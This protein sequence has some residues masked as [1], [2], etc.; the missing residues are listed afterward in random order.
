MKNFVLSL[1]AIVLLTACSSESEQPKSKNYI[2]LTTE[3]ATT[4]TED[5]Q[6]TLDITVMLGNTLKNDATIHFMLEGNEG[7]ILN[8]DTPSLDFKTGDKIKTLKVRSNNKS[9]L[10]EPRII[11]LRVKDFSD[12]NMQPWGEGI[13]ITV[14]PDSKTP[15]LTEEQEALLEGYRSNLGMDISRLIGRLNCKIKMIFP[16][17]E[18]GNMKGEPVFTDSEMKEYTSETVFT[19]SEQATADTPVLKMADNAMGLTSIFHQILNQEISIVNKIGTSF[20]SV[21][22][23]VHFDEK[24]ESFSMALDNLVIGTDGN[25][26][27]YVNERIDGEPM[28]YIPFLYRYSVWNRQEK[29]LKEGATVDVIVTDPETGEIMDENIGAAMSQLIEWGLTFNPTHYLRHSS[30]HEDS[31]DNGIWKKP[32]AQLDLDKGELK[33]SFP[34]DHA[35]SSGWTFIEVTYTLHPAR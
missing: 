13:A 21:A 7:D 27:F 19:L 26:N 3:S 18:V 8:I 28:S 10:S 11:T 16:I 17:E 20:P 4:L 22:Q 12:P 34:W 33:F 23:A 25:V 9:V 35:Y 30:M 2:R 5:S 1:L 31:W 32:S 14:N 29:M 24:N 6:H 15:I